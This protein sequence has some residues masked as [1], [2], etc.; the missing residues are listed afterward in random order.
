MRY[1]WILFVSLFAAGC[2]DMSPGGSGGPGDCDPGNPSVCTRQIGIVGPE[3]PVADGSIAP[4]SAQD[5]LV[6]HC[7]SFPPQEPGTC[8]FFVNATFSWSSSNTI[9]ATDQVNNLSAA[10]PLEVIRITTVTV[11]PAAVLLVPGDVRPFAA[12]AMSASDSEKTITFA[13]R[14]SNPAVGRLPTD[15]LPNRRSLALSRG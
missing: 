11:T 4:V 1:I 13:W 12:T 10:L 8:H 9:T 7:S 2:T 14:S 6:G 3:S 15:R 5:E